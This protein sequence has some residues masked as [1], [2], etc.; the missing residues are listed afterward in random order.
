MTTF[1]H[2]RSDSSDT[3]STGSSYQ[4]ILDH[5]LT[6]NASYEMPLRSMYTLNCAP[7]AQPMP[8]RR[9]TPSSSTS[10]SSSPTSPIMQHGW[11]EDSATQVFSENLMAQISSLPSQPASLPPSFI[12]NFLGK[13]FPP[14]LVCVD[15]PQA[16]TGLDY[17]KDLETRRKREVACAINR[18][19]YDRASLPPDSELQQQFPGIAQWLQ[20]IEDKERRVESLYTRIYVGLRRWVC[21]LAVSPLVATPLIICRS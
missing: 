8:H 19:G 2:A 7:R 20:G 6:Y 21:L 17:L 5:V 10:S 9:G 11:H 15:F 1:H 4:H 14:E 13:C 12:T 18:L 3:S 16:L